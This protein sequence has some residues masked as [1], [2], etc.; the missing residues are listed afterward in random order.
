MFKSSRWRSEK[1]KIKVVFKL[2]FHA[3]QVP[4]LAKDS[5]TVSLI[6]YEVGKPT[7]R[8]EKCAIR[9][10]T[11]RWENPIFETVK[12]LQEPKTGK[13]NEKM[14]QFIV[15]TGSSKAGYLGEVSLNFADYFDAIKP[16]TVSLPLKASISGTTLHITI[17]RIDGAVDQIDTEENP[18]AT[19]ESQDRSLRSKFNESETDENKKFNS[20]EDVSVDKSAAQ[21]SESNGNLLVSKISDGISVS[22]SESSSERN[23]PRDVGLRNTISRR[24]SG[25]FL[26]SLG[27]NSMPHKPATNTIIENYLEHQR[28]NTEWSVDSAPEG[29]V[30]NSTNSSDDNLL[31]ERSPH[32]FDTSVEKLKSDLVILARQAE[33]SEV[34]LQTLR[35]QVVKES[36]RGQDL[37]KEVISLR[38]ERDFLKQE[39]E[40]L[41]ASCKHTDD[42]KVFSKLQFED[43]DPR[44]LLQEVRQELNHEKD[45]NANLRVQLQKTQESNSELLLAV[46]DLDHMLEQKDREISHLSNK[47]VTRENGESLQGKREM[48]EDEEQTALE[49]LVKEHDDAKGTYML[50]QRI[51]DLCSEIEIY[52]RDKDE[53][54]MQMEQLALDYEI[55]KQEN[56]EF[57]SKLEQNNLQD[58][59]KAQYECSDSLANISELETQV[60]SLESDLMKRE[61]DFSA[62]L[63]TINE[64]KSQVESLED[65]LKKQEEDYSTSLV[66]INDLK[67]QVESLR[68]ELKK[69][70]DDLS[71]SSVTI[72][73][74][75]TKVDGLENELNRQEEDS[76]SSM[77]T[78]NELKSQVESLEQELEKQEQS[79]EADL[80]AVMRA[81]VEQEQRAIRAEEAMRKTRLTNAS[82][83]ERLQEEF[84]R[85]STQMASTF[86]ANERLA[87]KSVMEA[88]ELRL[89]K[90]HLEDMLEKANEDLSIVNDHYEEKLKDLSREIYLAKEQ[91]AQALLALEEKSAKLEHQK[92]QEDQMR[93]D[94]SKEIL[95]LRDDIEKLTAHINDLSGQEEKENLQVELERL[96]ESLIESEMLIQRGNAER[97]NLEKK[98]ASLG[99][100]SGS[101]SEELNTIRSLKDEKEKTIEALQLEVETLKAQYMNLE[102]SLLEAELEKENLKKQVISLKN[103]LKKKEDVIASN[104]KKL[105]AA[106]NGLKSSPK[107]NKSVPAHGTK[108]V[109]TLRERIKLLEGQIRL[110]ETALENSSNSFLEKERDLQ[111]KIEELENRMVELDD[112]ATNCSK[113]QLQKETETVN[114][115][116]NDDQSS[117]K[118]TNK[119]TLNKLLISTS[120]DGDYRNTDELLNAMALMKE[121]NESMEGELKDMQE[122]YSEISLK[123]AEVEGERQQLVMTV[124]NL[125]NV[126]KP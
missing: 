107:N 19:I 94:F 13:I 87:R 106:S 113:E 126:K 118:S 56:H 11:C 111:C 119:I 34:E 71:A 122:R 58:Q 47:S 79:F 125:K 30:D 83:A 93:E 50:E 100:V 78:I 53:L 33:V 43:N 14:Y 9:E 101:F 40:H 90:S 37:S 103:D 63:V 26:S 110:K 70:E 46:Q 55:L 96:K 10:G 77:V 66:T 3:T 76:S 86:D 25:S 24:G 60:E 116:S 51:I 98:I 112:N 109:A 23:T 42:A 97:S 6:P 31:K 72:H 99:K 81:K 22:G 114:E 44:I 1:N 8:L 67:S 91:A 15:S 39:C 7:V 115:S 105:K 2:Q 59:L 80:D 28:S 41:K 20:L 82:T 36:R 5:L 120:H 62:S 64:L 61:E 85:L 32:A 117:A 84:R 75:K 4:Q 21:N 121:K 68:Y 49:L 74:L 54:E 52:R 35:K 124:R 29:S 88:N 73:E 89:Q 123:F 17:Q 45:L 16:S 102:Q 104:D 12:L 57:L 38:E 95:M 18:I 65:E 108:E 27:H 48:D 92:V 69:Q